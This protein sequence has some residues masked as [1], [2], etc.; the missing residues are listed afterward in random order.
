MK[1]KKKVSK[2]LK[3]SWRKHVDVSDVEAF[4]DDKRL[5]ERLGVPFAK[6]KDDDLFTIDTKPSTLI[7]ESLF[8][9][10]KEK[11]RNL[12]LKCFAALE[13]TSAV[14]DPV[15]KRNTVRS[16]EERQHPAL[17]KKNETRRK[18]G[19][20]K[21][22]EFKELNKYFQ[23]RVSQLKQKPKRKVAVGNDPWVE[24]PDD[25]KLS[26]L[27]NWMN[28]NTL[29]HT[30]RNVSCFKESSNYRPEK[31]VTEVSS[32]EVPHPGISYNPTFQ[33]H[34]TLV[35][36][37]AEKE[38]DLQKKEAHLDRVTQNLFKQITAEQ[39]EK[40]WLEEMSEGLPISNSNAGK[41]TQDESDVSDGEYKAINPPVTREK[42][43]TI[44]QRKKLLKLKQEELQRQEDKEQKKKVQ[45]ISKIRT[46]MNEV[47]QN[48]KKQKRRELKRIK[49][50]AEKL[51]KPGRVGKNKF[52]G[53]ESNFTS[54]NELTGSLREIIPVGNILKD[55]FHS[56]QKR[57]LIE[58]VKPQFKKKN[59]RKVKAYQLSSHRLEPIEFSASDVMKNLKRKKKTK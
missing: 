32:F 7:R 3:S 17:R 51:E 40:N 34:L 52:T 44:K 57:S 25:S 38:I 9:S 54:V 56:L 15:I 26:K 21:K 14:P 23:R 45:D 11:A 1:T 4:L 8:T 29:L 33:D 47:L 59:K 6:R 46:I 36:E 2:K 5:E 31:V 50:A 20:L 48:E 27:K 30:V 42:K 22:K 19:I 37:V 12:P 39:N 35:K 24:T 53:D 16:K 58:V 18:A 49:K 43:K 55:R 10:K 13:N 41:D 28:S